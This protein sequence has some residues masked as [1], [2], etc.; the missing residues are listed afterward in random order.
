[1][2]GAGETLQGALDLVEVLLAKIQRISLAP[3]AE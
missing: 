2:A 3:I 1:M